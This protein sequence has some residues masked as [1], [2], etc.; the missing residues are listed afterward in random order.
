MDELKKISRTIDREIGTLKFRSFLS[1]FTIIA[2][3]GMLIYVLRTERVVVLHPKGGIWEGVRESRNDPGTLYIEGDD[4]V[5]K[6][7]ATFLTFSHSGYEQQIEKAFS[8]G[9]NAIKEAQSTLRESGFYN[10]IVVNNYRVISTVLSSELVAVDG[11]RMK[12]RILGQMVLENDFIR[13]T[14]NMNMDVVL[15]TVERTAVINPH[16]LSIERIDVHEDG[17]KTTSKENL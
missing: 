11:E 2:L 4:H 6:F 9:G 3:A 5:R 15:V 17:N 12:L 10:E 8:L 7:Y 1:G 16:G 14:R 13:E